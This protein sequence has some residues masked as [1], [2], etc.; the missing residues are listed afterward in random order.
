MKSTC[1]DTTLLGSFMENHDVARFA[2]VTSD[3]SLAK[4]AIAFTILADGIPISKSRTL[5]VFEFDN[6]N[7]KQSTKDKSSITP[8]VMF[9]TTE[10][11]SGSLSTPPLQ[12]S[13]PG[14]HH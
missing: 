1:A 11:R 13:T 12:L 14:S 2:S 10:T 5:G 8:V 3:F 7:T 4:N 9:R 6:S